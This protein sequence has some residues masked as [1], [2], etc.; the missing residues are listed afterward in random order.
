M[1]DATTDYI[2]TG[3]DMYKDRPEVFDKAVYWLDRCPRE[4]LPYLEEIVLEYLLSLDE[5]Q[6]VRVRRKKKMG[7]RRIVG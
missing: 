6:T 2:L 3:I 7:N 5:N 4:K 1:L